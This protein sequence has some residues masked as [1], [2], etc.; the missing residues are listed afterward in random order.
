MA[1][2]PAAEMETKWW[3]GGKSPF[4]LELRQNDD[5]VLPHE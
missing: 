5:G 4:N 1:Q 3:S 2:A